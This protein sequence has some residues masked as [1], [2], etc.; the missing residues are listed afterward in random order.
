MARVDEYGFQTFTASMSNLAMEKKK[1]KKGKIKKSKNYNKVMIV[2]YA[3]QCTTRYPTLKRLTI[4]LM[5]TSF[6]I[7]DVISKM[8]RKLEYTFHFAISASP[9][10]TS[11]SVCVY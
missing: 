10:S 9:A 6:N 7:L 2:A 11:V 8:S 1:K 4:F 3:S 5:L